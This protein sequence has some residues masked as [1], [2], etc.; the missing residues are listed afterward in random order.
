MVAIT[1][2]RTSADQHVCRSQGDDVVLGPGHRGRR[3]FGG[4]VAH[5]AGYPVAFVSA[6]GVC[7]A[8][9]ALLTFRLPHR[10]DP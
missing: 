8:A 2:Q 9:V 7:V 5:L 3:T 4:V 6:A 10:S 1:L